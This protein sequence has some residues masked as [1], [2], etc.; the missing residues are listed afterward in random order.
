MKLRHL[1]STTACSLSSAVAFAHEGHGDHVDAI[2]GVMHWFTQWDHVAVLALCAA[3]IGLGA[4][5]LL[6]RRAAHHKNNAPR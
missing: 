1:L 2:D 5:K 6:T 3:A 4:R